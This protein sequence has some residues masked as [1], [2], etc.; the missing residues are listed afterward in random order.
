MSKCR[1]CGGETYLADGYEFCK[2]NYCVWGQKLEAEAPSPEKHY[3]RI[4]MWHLQN[5]EERSIY[6][7]EHYPASRNY[8]DWKFIRFYW[9]KLLGFDLGMEFSKFWDFQISK[10]GNPSNILRGKRFACQEELAIIRQMVENNKTTIPKSAA[11]Y[12]F[13]SALKAFLKTCKYV[14]TDVRVLRSRIEKESAILEL[15]F[16]KKM[17]DGLVMNTIE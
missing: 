14:P 3:R 9:K 4:V 6:L 12:Q 8:S 5:A 7:F 1:K 11:F 13:Q 2:N 16:D 10:Y 17:N 15:V